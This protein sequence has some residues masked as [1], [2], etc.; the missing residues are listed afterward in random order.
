[1][2]E[3]KYS[4]YNKETEKHC[5]LNSGKYKKLRRGNIEPI[6][7]NKTENF[8][9]WS[10]FSKSIYLKKTDLKDLSRKK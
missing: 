10:G 5:V 6:P 9:T 4:S 3:S 1:M 2:L 7:I 8:N